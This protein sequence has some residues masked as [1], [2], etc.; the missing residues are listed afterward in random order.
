MEPSCDLLK[1]YVKNIG[2]ILYIESVGAIEDIKSLNICAELAETSCGIL[3]IG[4]KTAHYLIKHLAINIPC[5]IY[6][7]T[8]KTFDEANKTVVRDTPTPDI[9]SA[10]VE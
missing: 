2:A 8:M 3:N 6:E 7:V 9:P 10:K 5:A 1:E 4:V